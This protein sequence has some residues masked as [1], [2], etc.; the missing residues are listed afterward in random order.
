MTWSRRALFC[1]VAAVSALAGMAARRPD[2]PPASDA[3]AEADLAFRGFYGDARAVVRKRI[4]PVILVEMDQLI[5]IHE[6]RREEA[7]AI[8]P[9]YHRLKA[10]SH[11]PLALYVALAPHGEG[12]P[13]EALLA[14]LREFRSKIVA[15]EGALDGSGMGTEQLARSRRLLGRSRS[16]VDGVLA[17]G[18]FDP[19]GL[20]ALTRELAPL[21]LAHA[22]DAA[23]AQ[24]DG[25]HA[26]VKAWRGRLTAEEWAR[27][28][29]V[30]M[31][32][33][34]PRRHNTAVQ[35]FAKLLGLPGE[36]KRIVYAEELAGEEQ[37]LNLLAT[38]QL[39]GELSVSFFDDPERMEIDLLGNAASVYLDTLDLSR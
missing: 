38:H 5:L 2:P 36:S 20:G 6:G 16:F 37:A 12:P 15:V 28:R 14:R 8:P 3:F 1:G 26:Q 33:Q 11:V 10:V 35:F 34:M 19:A 39:D 25:Y 21:V 13:D 18:R 29:V 24:I 4:G 23:R 17:E 7:T 31:G 9:L 27:L 30:V 22:A 32:V